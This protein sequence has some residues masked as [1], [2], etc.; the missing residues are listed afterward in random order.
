MAWVEKVGRHS[1][2]VRYR[3]DSGYGSVP[4]FDSHETA[5]EYLQDMRTNQRRGTWL[6]PAGAKTRLDK[7][8]QRWIE[9]IDVETR[10]EEN[11]RRCLR[12][13]ILPRWG[14]LGLGEITASAVTEWLKQLRQRYAASTVVTLR[15]ILSMILDDAIDERLIPANPV[16][17]RR[18]RGRRRDHAPTPRERVWAMPDQ[19]LR[20]AEQATQ[21]GGPSAGLLVITT[22]WT[23]CRWGEI[24]GLQRDHIDLDRG[25]ITIDPETG[26]L[27]ESAHELWLGPPKTP[28]SARTIALPPFLITQLGEHLAHSSSPFVFTSPQGK[29]LRRSTFDR[30]VFRPAVDGS[31]RKDTQSVKP[32][33]TFHG[34]RHSH[35]TWLI[36]DGIPEIAQAR[37]LGH[38]LANRLVEVYSHVAPEIETRLLHQLERR[39]K[40]ATTNKRSHRAPHR[41]R[42]PHTAPAQRATLHR[43]RLNQKTQFNTTMQRTSNPDTRARSA[44]ELLQLDASSD[45]RRPWLSIIADMREALRPGKTSDRE[46]FIKKWS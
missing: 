23:G 32:G 3:T 14:H 46:S 38:H 40:Q 44:P 30:R 28:A 42:D 29:L 21:L 45:R 24:A 26:A 19:V 20:I 1:W 39:W 5:V 6:D 2:R 13:H 9:T 17:R 11:Y 35:K 37:R 33:L 41:R 43:A 34:L 15:T 22:A 27:H 4:G 7:W 10:T 12:L 18:R 36:A 8:V 31:L 25:V 16:R